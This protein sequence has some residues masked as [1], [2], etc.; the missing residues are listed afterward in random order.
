MSQLLFCVMV[1]WRAVNIAT[2]YFIF[3]RGTGS[4][5]FQTTSGCSATFPGGG[6]RTGGR[7]GV[8]VT[9][10]KFACVIPDPASAARTSSRLVFRPADTPTVNTTWSG[11]KAALRLAVTVM[12][13]ESSFPYA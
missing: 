6:T 13:F 3:V 1:F 5:K 4:V 12:E 10:E 7:P 11:C 2:V 8:V 9:P